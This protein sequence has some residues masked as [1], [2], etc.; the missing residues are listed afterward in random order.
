M[1]E[2]LIP[3]GFGVISDLQKVSFL[4]MGDI[5]VKFYILVIGQF[6]HG[7]ISFRCVGKGEK[8]FTPDIACLC[9]VTQARERLRFVPAWAY[10]LGLK[11]FRD[12]LIVSPAAAG[13]CQF[14]SFMYPFSIAS[15]SVILTQPGQAF[16][17]L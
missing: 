17:L 10:L 5:R 9:S 16:S 8:K 1:P 12:R 3:S 14:F 11:A 2:Q 6:L 13:S 4:V 15:D 7:A